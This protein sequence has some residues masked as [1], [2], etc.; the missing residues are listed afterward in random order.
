MQDGELVKIH[1]ETQAIWTFYFH[2]KTPLSYTAG[3]FVEVCL[4][5]HTRD[6]RGQKR[7]FTLSSSPTDELLSITT[8]FA[9]NASSSFKKA[10]FEL[11]PGE[12]I[13]ISEPMGDFVLPRD[14]SRP[15]V[16]VAGGIGLTPFHSM[17]S[18]LGA[19]GETRDIKFLY[20]VRNQSEIIF[21]NTFKTAGIEPTIVVA[22][23][24]KSWRGR[25]GRLDANTILGLEKPAETA[26]I[27]V[28]GPEPMTEALEKDLKAAGLKKSQLVLD[29]FPGYENTYA[30]I[31]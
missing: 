16:F 14:T 6:D 17:L 31:A 26:L 24:S 27:Y 23:P 13:S 20:S 9:G 7:W 2:P 11:E 5:H 19:S 8:K 3:Q 18:W 30:K 12:K 15:L 10:L 4:P 21:T 25:T 22:E 28:S 29:F 1:H